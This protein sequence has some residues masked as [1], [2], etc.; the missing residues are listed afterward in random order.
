MLNIII[1]LILVLMSAFFSGMET[2]FVSI[3]KLRVKYL[4]K[5]NFKNALLLEKLKSDPNKLLILIL[6]GNNVVNIG[7]SAVATSLAIDYFG[8]YGVG[9]ATG[10]MTFFILVFG[11]IAPKSYCTV[12][13][14]KIALKLSPIVNVLSKIFSPFVFF[15][16][17]ITQF[18]NKVSNNNKKPLITEDELMNIVNIGEEIG[19]I[20]KDEKEMIKNIFNFNDIEV[21]NVMV[22]RSEIFAIDINN[23]IGDVIDQ[24]I[25]MGYSRIPVY[26]SDLD[27]LKGVLFVKDIIGK[28][29]DTPIAKI[30]RDPIIIPS[31]RKLNDIFYDMNNKK[32]HIAFVVD[33]YGTIVGLVTIEDLL[34]EIVGEIYDE[35][36]IIENEIVKTKRGYIVNGL[37][38]ISEICE[39]TNI[40]IEGEDFKTISSYLLD[41]IGYL[42]KENE[43][44]ELNG[45]KFYIKDVNHNRINKVEII[46]A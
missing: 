20:R 3:S 5:K 41:S 39:K 14:E 33:E 28:K 8:N 10:L 32:I 4:V 22:P 23:D 29:E 45:Y 36:D 18:F 9:I 25:N 2:A 17:K 19:T 43:N 21:S 30:M 35:T 11:E 7:A 6:L 46:L 15:F 16:S 31:N 13:A 24:I 37:V 38:E 27:D 34:E 1:L 26:D 40:K 44:F 12:H 42:P